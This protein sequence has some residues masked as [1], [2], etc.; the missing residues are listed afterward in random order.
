MAIK[1]VVME[2]VK[3]SETWLKG[4]EALVRWFSDMSTWRY[5][6]KMSWKHICIYTSV[7]VTY[8]VS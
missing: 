5:I 1:K 3:T 7:Y 2:T 6:A 4:F 8:R